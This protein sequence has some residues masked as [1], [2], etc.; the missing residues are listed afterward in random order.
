MKMKTDI[1]KNFLWVV[2]IFAIFAYS[3]KV[4]FQISKNISK[5]ANIEE[6]I[7]RVNKK[8]EETKNKIAI[9]DDRIKALDN[10]FE[11]E[12]LARNMLKMVKENEVIYKYVE[13][14]NKKDVE[15]EEK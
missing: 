4:Y 2:V 10:D 14:D 12:K 9:Y 11:K 8:I 5:K 3:V 13:K 6:E 1:K 15:V 7:V